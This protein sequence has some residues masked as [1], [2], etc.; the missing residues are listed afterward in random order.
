MA[1]P[2]RTTSVAAAA[3]TAAAAA[4]AAAA[5]CIRV[6]SVDVNQTTEDDEESDRSRP[7]CIQQPEE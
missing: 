7:P 2:R 3:E 6:N 5:R 1:D 4:A